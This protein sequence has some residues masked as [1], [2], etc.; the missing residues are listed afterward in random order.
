MIICSRCNQQTTFSG[1]TIGEIR[2]K[3]VNNVPCYNV[4]NADPEIS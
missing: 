1:Q 2:V 3:G 4:K